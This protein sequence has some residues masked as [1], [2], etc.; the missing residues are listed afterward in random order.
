MCLGTVIHGPGPDQHPG[1]RQGA[2]QVKGQSPA[3]LLAEET[4]QGEA[5]DAA[6]R[7]A[8]VDDGGDDTSG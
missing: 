2:E 3:E 6:E 4:G 1:K 5:D 7:A 8:G